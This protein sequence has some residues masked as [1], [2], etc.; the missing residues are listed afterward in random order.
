MKSK[1][2]FFLLV[3]LAVGILAGCRGRTEKSEGTVLLSVSDFNG[4]PVQV[5][6]ASG[7]Y[8]IE[9]V[10]ISNIPKDPTGTTSNLQDVEMR[11]YEVT[12]TRLDTGTRVPPTLVNSIFGNVAVGATTQY[13]NLPFLR[14]DQLNNPPLSDLLQFGFDQQTRSQVIPMRI[15]LRF[16]G[17]TLAGDDIA[18]APASFT[19]DI[20]P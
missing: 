4:L 16:F 6:V 13:D 20:L 17:R 2:S 19:V 10:T 18:T 1:S 14:L 8:Q 5:S 7:P 15:T 11:A 12:Y 9:Q 3:I